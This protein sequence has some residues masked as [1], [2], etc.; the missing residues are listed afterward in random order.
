MS[1]PLVYD[2]VDYGDPS[3]SDY[4]EDFDNTCPDCDGDGG[5]K[6][7]DYILEC[8]T[9]G[10]TGRSYRRAPQTGTEGEREA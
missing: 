2:G 6:W 5:D 7:C 4:T 8:P 9:C 1:A 3:E 10:G